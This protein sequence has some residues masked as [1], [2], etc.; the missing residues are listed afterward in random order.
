MVFEYNVVTL[1][2]IGDEDADWESELDDLGEDGWQLVS[3][4]NMGGGKVRAFMM[5][6]KGEAEEETDDESEEESE[7]DDDE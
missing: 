4:V 1:D 5:K 6:E 3:V 7:E 2:P